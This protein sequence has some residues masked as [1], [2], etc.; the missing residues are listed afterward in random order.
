MSRFKKKVLSRGSSPKWRFEKACIPS[1]SASSEVETSITRTLSVGRSASERAIASSAATPVALSFAPGTASRRAMSASAAAESAARR[2]P[3]LDEGAAAGQRPGAHQQGDGDHGSHQGRAGVDALDQP[4][5]AAEH[6][7]GDRRVVEQAGVRRVV[8]GHEDDG[9]IGV[10][11][12]AFGDDRGRG[13]LRQEGAQPPASRGEVVG[14]GRAH[15]AGH[16]RGKHAP[17]T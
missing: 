11:R 17:A 1:Q 8:M 12:A 6:R 13:S 9:A 2:R 16:R 10:G 3:R 4:R 14:G 5:K 15:H 7:L